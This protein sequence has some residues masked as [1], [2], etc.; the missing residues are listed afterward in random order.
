MADAIGMPEHGINSL[1]SV[2]GGAAAQQRVAKV[3]QRVQPWTINFFDDLNKKEWIFADRIIVF[4]INTD[5]L[6]LGILDTRFKL[7]V[8]RARSGFESFA[9]GILVRTLGEPIAAAAS[10]H[11]LLKV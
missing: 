6:R 4:E 9:A 7:S 8:V 3:G 2:L 11:R 10:I 1:V 5:A